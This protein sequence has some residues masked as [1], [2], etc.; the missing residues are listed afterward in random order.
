MP[1][2]IGHMSAVS[3]GAWKIQPLRYW[4]DLPPLSKVT[5]AHSLLRLGREK[6]SR[7]LC[8]AGERRRHPENPSIITATTAAAIVLAFLCST[9]RAD[10]AL[11]SLPLQRGYYVD[12]GTPCGS[13]SLATL[14]TVRRDGIGAGGVLYR[15]KRVE[16]TGRTAYR[17]T[18][19]QINNDGGTDGT[20]VSE[21]E[22]TGPSSF[23]WKNA[24]GFS[25]M[26]FCLQENLPDPWRTNDI[27]ALIK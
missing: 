1:A 16:K 21:Y 14:V 7:V 2:L 15:F 10:T 26:R 8:R 17:V 6:N 5:L 3:N 11:N 19:D 22:M 24:F 13:A 20:S 9:A 23:R 27:R 25:R 12:T 4:K 18:A